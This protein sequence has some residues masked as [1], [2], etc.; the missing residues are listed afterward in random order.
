MKRT[1]L[2]SLLVLAVLVKSCSKSDDAIH[3]TTPTDGDPCVAT[4]VLS[5]WMIQLPIRQSGSDK[6]IILNTQALR[7]LAYTGQ[8]GPLQ[9][10]VR[11]R[12]ITKNV[13]I[14][15]TGHASDVND[16]GFAGQLQIE[17]WIF[18]MYHPVNYPDHF[19]V[20]NVD[21]KEWFRYDHSQEEAI[22]QGNGD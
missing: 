12:Y 5:N 14:L 3:E 1:F 19:I 16:V 10:E 20:Y 21:T 4:E 13:N 11:C 6:L 2:A 17:D 22:S 7:T 9:R 18:A 8:T 15:Q